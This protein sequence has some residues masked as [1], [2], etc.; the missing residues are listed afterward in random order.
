VY[1]TVY[2][3]KI[4]LNTLGLGTSILS[5]GLVVESVVGKEGSRAT[6]TSTTVISH[7]NYEQIIICTSD[8]DYVL[9]SV[10][11][12]FLIHPAI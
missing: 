1:T 5:K 3:R 2:K 6:D 11:P 10:S 8:F 12:T 4:K 7:A 9:L